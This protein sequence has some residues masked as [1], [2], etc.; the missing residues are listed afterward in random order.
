MPG[1]DVT[2]TAARKY[3]VK[4]AS[5]ALVTKTTVEAA[6]ARLEQINRQAKH[7]NATLD[8]LPA[9][10]SAKVDE[11]VTI[12]KGLVDAVD[13]ISVMLQYLVDRD[14]ARK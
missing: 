4:A 3:K 11:V 9:T 5:D 10:A 6:V 1:K 2:R 8:D 12:V 13:D 7:A 14:R